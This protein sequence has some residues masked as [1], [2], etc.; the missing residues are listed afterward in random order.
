[1]KRLAVSERYRA[2]IEDVER[3]VSERARKV[4]GSA[5]NIR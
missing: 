2:S 4:S 5:T 1:V 3:I